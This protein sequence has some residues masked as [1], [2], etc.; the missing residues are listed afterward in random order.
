[1][2]KF[3]LLIKYITG[4]MSGVVEYLLGLLNAALAAIDPA[5]KKEMQH[6]LNIAEQ[7][8]SALQ[9]LKFLCPTKW[10][11]AYQKT[12]VAAQNVVLSLSDLALTYDELA[13]ICNDFNVARITW[14]G[15][16]DETCV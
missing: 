3:K 16:D 1:M 15:E 13:V 2:S 9:T 14:N 12:V 6:A 4:G 7:A 8:L 10:Q 5:K 11:T